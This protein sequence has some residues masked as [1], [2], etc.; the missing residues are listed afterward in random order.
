MRPAHNRMF[1]Y[2]CLAFSSVVLYSSVYL[3]MLLFM[4]C[5]LFV[6]SVGAVVE[7]PPH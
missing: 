7:E 4:H 3:F 2:Y 6:R 5:L 1:P